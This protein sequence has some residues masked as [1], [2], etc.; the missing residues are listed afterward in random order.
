MLS[1]YLPSQYERVRDHRLAADPHALVV[2]RIRDVMR[3]YAAAC[4]QQSAASTGRF[5]DPASRTGGVDV[6]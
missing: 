4:G 1:Q 5:A 3:R 2:D 6:L